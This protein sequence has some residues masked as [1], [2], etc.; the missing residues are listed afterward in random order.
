VIAHAEVAEGTRVLE[1]G[2]GSGALTRRL[3]AHGAIVTAV[4]IDRGL[5]GVL[6]DE[7]AD[8]ARFTLIQADVL[9]GKHR[10]N[11]GVMAHLAA[12]GQPFKLVANLPF[13]AATPLILLL[14]ENG[15]LLSGVVV[16]VQAEVADR[17][18]AVA[19]TREYGVI[20]VLAQVLSKPE[21]LLK[22]GRQSFSP[23]PKVDAAV[24]KMTPRNCLDASRFPYGALKELVAW[25]FAQR[26]KKLRARVAERWPE[27]ES[28]C[29]LDAR[30]EDID[31]AGY[32]AIAEVIAAG[33]LQ[34]PPP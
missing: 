18:I 31:P 4:E 6:R 16:T 9:D 15:P 32:L 13:N 14:L 10:L 21:K 28:V 33:R 11:E 5:C 12:A 22:I 24:L 8:C 7:F 25:A 27:A 2:P 17:F 23:P 19:G 20:S 34:G 26:R 30:P 3:L 1:V 29:P